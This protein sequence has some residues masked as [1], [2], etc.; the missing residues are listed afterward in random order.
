MI[1]T[2]VYFIQT[3]ILG[4]KEEIKMIEQ[5]LERLENKRG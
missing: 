1:D 2:D 4:I 5:A 3:R